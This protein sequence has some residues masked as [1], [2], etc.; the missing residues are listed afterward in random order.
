M[1][2][3]H[4]LIINDLLT[5]DY[6]LATLNIKRNN[7]NSLLLLF[8]LIL[9]VA[10]L[11]NAKTYE[12]IHSIVIN[13]KRCNIKEINVCRQFALGLILFFNTTSYLK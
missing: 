6:N 3:G 9:K 10:R 4:F 8:L 11:I 13:G 5:F 7:N 1:Q 12:G 2:E